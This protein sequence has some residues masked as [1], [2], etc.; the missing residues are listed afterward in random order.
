MVI[1]TGETKIMA[2]R[3]EVLIRG[4]LCIN[5]RTLEQISTCNYLVF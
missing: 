4:K 2:F 5:D 3:G 1:N